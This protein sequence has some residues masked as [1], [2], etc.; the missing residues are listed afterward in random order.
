MAAI[1][2][3]IGKLST[4]LNQL[5]TNLK[6]GNNIDTGN[7]K[8]NI[9][10]INHELETYYSTLSY[11]QKNT[12]SLMANISSQIVESLNTIQSHSHN[13]QALIPQLEQIIQ[14]IDKI[15]TTKLEINV[16]N[17]GDI[18]S[19]VNTMSSAFKDIQQAVNKLG[20]DPSLGVLKNQLAQTSSSIAE[21]TN[22]IKNTA[23]E[24]AKV[25]EKQDSISLNL[26]ALNDQF[27]IATG[28]SKDL[29]KSLKSLFTTFRSNGNSQA[30]ENMHAKLNSMQNDINALKYVT[31]QHMETGEEIGG[32]KEELN[33]FLQDLQTLKSQARQV[34]NSELQQASLGDI[35]SL[36]GSLSSMH[37]AA[38]NMTKALIDNVKKSTKLNINE[39]EI[40][41]REIKALGASAHENSD[42]I[43]IRMNELFA[44]RLENINSAIDHNQQSLLNDMSNGQ[45]LGRDWQYSIH[46]S[47]DAARKIWQ[48]AAVTQYTQEK[49]YNPFNRTDTRIKNIKNASSKVAQMQYEYDNGSQELGELYAKAEQAGQAGDNEAKNALLKR[50]KARYKSMVELQNR[51]NQQTEYIGGQWQLLSQSDKERL[52]EEGKQIQNNIEQLFDNARSGS[53]NLIS[54]KEAF[55]IESDEKVDASFKKMTK[56]MN[57]MGEEIEK[58]GENSESIFSQVLS[59]GKSVI[60]KITGLAS[61]FKNFLGKFGIGTA[62]LGPYDTATTTYGM[63]RDQ[64]RRRFKAMGTDAYLGI[65]DLGNSAIIAQNRLLAGNRLYMASGGQ[66]KQEAID[67]SYNSLVR[68]VGGAYGSSPEQAAGDLNQL[69]NGMATIQNVYGIDQSTMN[70]TI[71]TYYKDMRMSADEASNAF[72]KLMQTAQS[73]G[74]PLNQYLKIVSG[75]A[76][77]YMGI[78]LTGD[79]ADIVLN[80]LMSRG[81]RIE[82]AQELADQLG[83]AMSKFAEDKGQVGFAAMMNGSDPWHAIAQASYTHEANGD[84][85]KG[86]G[87]EIAKGM[88]TMFNLYMGVYGDNPDM[89]RMG[90][91][92]QLR[93]MGFN[94]RA[95][96]TLA[97]AYL[98]YGGN[99]EQFQK[100]LEE[101]SAEKDNPNAGLE[102]KTKEVLKQLQTMSGTLSAAD[103]EEARAKGK[104]YEEAQ[105]IG[106]K[107]DKIV[108]AFSPIFI[109]F[110]KMMI[111]FSGWIADKAKDIVTSD[112]FKKTMDML[113]PWVKQLPKLFLIVMAAKAAGSVIGTGIDAVKGLFTLPGMIVGGATAAGLYYMLNDDS[114]EEK[115]SQHMTAGKNENT[116]KLRQT[117]KDARKVIEDS[118]VKFKELYKYATDKDAALKAVR[119]KD[120]DEVK[121]VK[122]KI[123]EMA[124]NNTKKDQEEELA[125]QSGIAD[126][127]ILMNKYNE[128]K[129]NV[130][131]IDKALKDERKYKNNIGLKIGELTAA[132]KETDDPDKKREINKAIDNL[133]GEENKSDEKIKRLEK[134]YDSAQKEV[135]KSQEKLGIDTKVGNE[136]LGDETKGANTRGNASNQETSGNEHDNTRKEASEAHDKLRTD[137]ASQSDATEKDVTSGQS[138]LREP[139]QQGLQGIN[140]QVDALAKEKGINTSKSGKTPLLLDPNAS[141]FAP[142]KNPANVSMGQFKQLPGNQLWQNAFQLNQ[143]AFNRQNYMAQND[144]LRLYDHKGPFFAMTP[145]SNSTSLPMISDKDRTYAGNM[146]DKA[147]NDGITVRSTVTNLLG[148]GDSNVGNNTGNLMSDNSAVATKNSADKSRDK[149]QKEMSQKISN[150]QRAERDLSLLRNEQLGDLAKLHERLM[151][152][153][154]ASVKEEH[155]NLWKMMAITQDILVDLKSTIARSGAVMAKAVGGRGSGGGGAVSGSLGAIAQKVSQLT[156]IRADFIA[157]QMAFESGYTSIEEAEKDGYWGIKD[158][159]LSGISYFGNDPAKRGTARP[160]GEG[161]YY[162]HFNSWD[163][164]AEA[165]A[166]TLKNYSGLKSAQTLEDYVQ[167]L[168]HNVEGNSY[169]YNNKASDFQEHVQNYINGLRTR[170]EQLQSK[171]FIGAGSSGSMNFSGPIHIL[172]QHENSAGANNWC[173]ATSFGMIYNAVNGTN[174]DVDYIHNNLWNGSVVSAFSNVGIE[175]DYFDGVGQAGVRQALQLAQQ[176]NTAAYLYFDSPG[177]TNKF[178]SSGSGTHAIV[179]QSIGNGMFHYYDPN[180]AKEG[181]ISLEELVNES[182]NNNEVHVLKQ[183]LSGS[184]SGGGSPFM[185]M[186]IN[187][188]SNA[189]EVGQHSREEYAANPEYQMRMTQANMI[190]ADG[191]VY[192]DIL[193]EHA[194]QLAKEEDENKRKEREE[195]IAKGIGPNGQKFADEDVKEYTD[196]GKSEQEAYQELSK[197][198][199]YTLEG[200]K[201]LKYYGIDISA[202]TD[203]TKK[204]ALIDKLVKNI[205]SGRGPNGRKID[206]NDMKYLL[207]KGYT[208]EQ[209]KAELYAHEKYK[210]DALKGDAGFWL[211][212]VYNFKD[213]G[214]NIDTLAVQSSFGTFLYHGVSSPEQAG[215]TNIGGA[216]YVNQA[217]IGTI[218]EA[219]DKMST[220]QEM[221][222]DEMEEANEE[223]EEKDINKLDAHVFIDANLDDES[224]KAFMDIINKVL[225]ASNDGVIDKEELAAIK[226]AILSLSKSG[227]A[228]L[229]SQNIRDNAAAR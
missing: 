187:T 155:G 49:S 55:H 69:A 176:R 207:N 59:N 197:R 90:A 43:S 80:N 12:V 96:S 15:N 36:Y 53:N 131:R 217:R 6:V 16:D 118:K 157:A 28:N 105:V 179:V 67:E 164:Y 1:E 133:K 221:P 211:S 31:S 73:A 71:K 138:G 45:N 14:Q 161:G 13:A 117:I 60:D 136:Q 145:S 52:G 188:L 56:S 225:A 58:A 22:S 146:W 190:G 17:A 219:V 137:V 76:Q 127:V 32:A 226:S 202:V 142:D 224:K 18:I 98:Q 102:N 89:R 108:D 181:N 20:P 50:A 177:H 129:G 48:N 104:L 91:T 218:N 144:N 81:M 139:V 205:R 39:K 135:T 120:S 2:D 178:T 198:A 9:E 209:A 26:K 116:E 19:Q 213:K 195:N 47:G 184:I 140:T 204:D 112:L 25:K 163:E 37:D 126:D 167:A 8:S 3:A 156:G 124:G 182:F 103:M 186:D 123:N 94:Q 189:I 11:S 141:D 173:T 79:A 130:N 87:K 38:G 200:E 101:K 153:F 222:I 62:L 5:N 95:A 196:Q 99:S 183:G 82:V 24:L 119:E 151:G 180:G 216:E 114:T 206:D 44:Q 125:E 111:Q 72:V 88:D 86:W 4:Q 191:H 109:Q 169:F 168:T 46:G 143:Q 171:G 77:K 61:G 42:N 121:A 152:M 148:I 214:S 34:E 75:L 201:L 27:T 220:M 78:G 21:V 51:I 74:V 63:H 162:R 175:T 30:F 172:N 110:E 106:L 35:T 85:R 227:N 150:E 174:Y 158:F 97:S 165:Y 10:A 134:E 7:V 92:D 113:V 194:E 170:Y 57:E 40:L 193:E 83:G 128:Q 154:Q 54:L 100:L 65:S 228:L 215:L 107:I 223:A 203:Q 208:T 147:R 159:N 149:T 229:N 132:L 192:S 68:N 199:D 66:I 93:K 33:K 23:N 185:G 212:D 166:A 29:E 70:D 41:E 64:S 84:P 115:A 210:Y 160:R 122:Q